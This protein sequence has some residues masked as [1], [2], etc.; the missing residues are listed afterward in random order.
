MFVIYLKAKWMSFEYKVCCK[1]ARW[2]QSVQTPLNQWLIR[3]GNFLPNMV[4]LFGILGLWALC[5]KLS[6]LYISYC[7]THN[8]RNGSN[9]DCTTIEYKGAKERVADKVYGLRRRQC[10]P[11]LCLPRYQEQILSICSVTV[12]TQIESWHLRTSEGQVNIKKPQWLRIP[13]PF[14]QLIARSEFQ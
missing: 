2:R 11:C 10:T 1:K 8:W 3:I 14:I 7:E 5:V 12:N 6:Y 13:N 4:Q 9:M